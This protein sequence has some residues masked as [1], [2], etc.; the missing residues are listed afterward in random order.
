M[1]QSRPE[2]KRGSNFEL[3]FGRYKQSGHEHAQVIR[4]HALMSQGTYVSS[5]SVR[6]KGNKISEL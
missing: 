3:I 5:R 4:M 6:S 2:T 1:K